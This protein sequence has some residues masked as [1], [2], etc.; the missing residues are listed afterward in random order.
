MQP[1][2]LSPPARNALLT[3]HIAATAGVFGADLVLLAL[4]VSGIRGGDP[5][6]IYPAAHLAG[7]WLVAPLAILSLG[8]GLLLA[9]LTQW[10]L[11]RYWW[12]AIKLVITASL[13][14]AAL[15]VLVPRL[16]NA[17]SAATGPAPEPLSFAERLPL[18]LAPAGASTL[19]LVALVLAVFKPGWRLWP[20][21]T[22]EAAT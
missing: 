4:C 18:G 3:A 2:K 21:T 15:F 10:G 12:V 17:A 1:T 7:T 19:L 14:G 8:T 5:L 6:T 22:E 11:L 9:V 16:K 20:A 13:T